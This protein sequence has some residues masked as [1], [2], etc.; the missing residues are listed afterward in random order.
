[1]PV[2]ADIRLVLYVRGDMKFLVRSITGILIACS[3]FGTANAQTPAADRQ[4]ARQNSETFSK[5]S[6]LERRQVEAASKDMARVL[7]EAVAAR[8]ALSKDFAALNLPEVLS[9]QYR[10]LDADGALTHARLTKG[11]A[12]VRRGQAEQIQQDAALLGSI[13]SSA[14]PEHLK[15][16][17]RNAQI[18]LVAESQT[19]RERQW[20][21]QL[22]SFD[23]IE[24]CVKLLTGAEWEI[25]DGQYA[26]ASNAD[27][28]AFLKEVQL[29]DG[30]SSEGRKLEAG[31]Q[32]RVDDLTR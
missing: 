25:Q 23:S 20:S 10:K 21:L 24:R 1:M 32:R 14:L 29:L 3:L 12:L 13:T 11:R 17:Y 30:L 7:A 22:Q 15:A 8:N 19:A 9:P 6:P 28:Q 31:Q 2:Q 4:R 16:Y 5:M 27:L 26:F 18:N